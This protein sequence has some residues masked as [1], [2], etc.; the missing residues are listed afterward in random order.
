MG[1]FQDGEVGRLQKSALS[2][3]TEREMP[4]GFPSI[5]GTSVS[6]LQ[7]KARWSIGCKKKTPSNL[8]QRLARRQC[9][10]AT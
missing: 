1:A 9:Y 3:G 2:E 10:Y 7:N 6:F 4:Q 5:S 8:K